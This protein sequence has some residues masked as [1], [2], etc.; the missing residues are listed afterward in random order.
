MYIFIKGL[1]GYKQIYDINNSHKC[2]KIKEYIFQTFT[3]IINDSNI[4]SIDYMVHN[5]IKLDYNKKFKYYGVKENDTVYLIYKYKNK[6][7]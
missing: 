6:K 7:K 2:D 3:E 4:S 1:S 5:G